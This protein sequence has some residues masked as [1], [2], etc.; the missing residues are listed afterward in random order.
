MKRPWRITRAVSIGLLIGGIVYWWRWEHRKLTRIEEVRRRVA[1]NLK[2]QLL[3]RG[4]ALGDAAFIRIF[5]ES[6]E[7]ELWLRPKDTD[8]FQL[9]K[10]YT[11]AAMSGKLGP[12]LAEGDGQA[13]EG[14]YEVAYHALNPNSAFHLSFDIGYPNA[15]DAHNNR[16]GSW[17]MVHGGNASV[18]CFAMTNPVIEEI[19]LIAEAALRKGQPTFAVH[20]F[21]FRMTEERIRNAASSEWLAFW[22]NLR[23]GYAKFEKIHLPP[24]VRVVD[25]RYVF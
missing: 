8:R 9:W 10:T 13:P 12:K 14:F 16:T 25:G 3:T 21:P 6:R 19:Y 7:M 24:V 23:E 1:P 18:G 15:F 22:E 17:I 4:F 5:K 2:K 11:I 20:V